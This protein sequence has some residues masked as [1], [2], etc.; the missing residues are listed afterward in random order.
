MVSGREQL[1]GKQALGGDGDINETLVVRLISLRLAAIS[2]LLLNSQGKGSHWYSRNES[3][4]VV[5]FVETTAL[6]LR[7]TAS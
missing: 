6:N 2:Q 7:A 3:V 5:V 4:L 1:T